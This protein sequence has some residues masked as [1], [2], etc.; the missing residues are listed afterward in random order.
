MLERARGN[1]QGAGENR[2]GTFPFSCRRWGGSTRTA[3]PVRLEPIGFPTG[4][5]LARPIQIAQEADEDL[6]THVSAV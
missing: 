4:W 5:S 2:A 3:G 1:R 6:W